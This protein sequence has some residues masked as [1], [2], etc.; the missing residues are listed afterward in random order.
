M[1]KIHCP[2]FGTSDELLGYIEEAGLWTKVRYIMWSF[3]RMV[4]RFT[5]NLKARW[6]GNKGASPSS[7]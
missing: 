7:K 3:S 1:N 6:F 5:G 2:S 4:G